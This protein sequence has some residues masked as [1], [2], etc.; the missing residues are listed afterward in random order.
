MREI[1]GYLS[2]RAQQIWPGA[3][4][5]KLDEGNGERWA[6]E[7]PA[8]TERSELETVALGTTF[9]AARQAVDALISAERARRSTD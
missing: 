9:G 5:Y 4:V 2:R 6:L 8:T 1:D 3:L 7:R